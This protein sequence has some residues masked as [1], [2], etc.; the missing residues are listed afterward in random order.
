MLTILLLTISVLWVAS[1]I[2]L[3]VFR[4]SGPDA[5][6]KDSGSLLILN[7]VIYTA[8]AVGMYLGAT[9]RGHFPVPVTVF[10]L[11]LLAIVFG[12]AVRWW[13]V[14]SLR[15]F[16]TVD[17]AIHPDHRLVRIGPYRL[18]RHPAYAG[19][20]LSFAGLAICGSSWVSLLV[21]LVPIT[22][23][24]LYRIRVEERA[25]LLA[26]PSEYREYSEHTF[27]ILPGL[28]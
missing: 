27:R 11:G 23:A 18:V 6:R 3:A 1:E 17:V 16:F 10:W 24:F 28:Y 5:A 19:S 20:L 8:V 13:A 21:T 7:A 14:L 15:R 4:R 2:G 26:F 9:G 12:L 22:A 25:L